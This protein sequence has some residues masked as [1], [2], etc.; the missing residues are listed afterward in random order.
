VIEAKAELPET[1]EAAEAPPAAPA[2]PGAAT[3]PTWT[4]DPPRRVGDVQ[5]EVVVTDEYSSDEECEQA[6]NIVVMLKTY[7]HIQKLIGAPYLNQ[8]SYPKPSFDHAWDDPR[9]SAL[10]SNGVTLDYVLR[11]I[12]KNEYFDTVERSVGP[13]K[14]LYTQV[15]FTREVDRDLR[16]LWQSSQRRDQFAKVG[17]GAASILGL[18]S[19]IWGLLKIDTATKGYYTKRLFIGVPAAI[20]A[21]LLLM[22]LVKTTTTRSDVRSAV[23]LPPGYTYSE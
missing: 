2:K 7:E 19:M 20:I 11:K 9:L 15:Q 5:S 18:L 21:M 12:A 13:M 8:L 4:N 1:P 3:R 14:K 22:S 23:P 16:Q 10:N 17:V 6:R